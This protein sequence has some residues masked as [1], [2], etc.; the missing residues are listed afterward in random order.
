MSDWQNALNTRGQRRMY[1]LGISVHPAHQGRGVGRALI[2]Y[3]TERADAAGVVAWVQSSEAAV[4]AFEKEGF[5][6]RKEATVTADLDEYATRPPRPTGSGD[7]GDGG[8]KWGSYTWRY[9]VR[10]PRKA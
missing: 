6:E 9:M 1:I 8:G 7:D 10:E 3:G 4:K 2:R 5:V